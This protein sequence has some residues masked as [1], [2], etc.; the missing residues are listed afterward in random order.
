LLILSNTSAPFSGYS[1]ISRRSVNVDAVSKRKGE[2]IVFKF[3]VKCISIAAIATLSFATPAFADA[4][5]DKAKAFLTGLSPSDHDVV[6]IAALVKAMTVL[7]EKN[8]DA[9]LIA[10]LDD[11]TDF[12]FGRVSGRSPNGLKQAMNS[13]INAYAN[14]DSSI[15][16]NIMI[17]CHSDYIEAR[18]AVS[19]SIS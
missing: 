10:K 14:S 11:A 3:T 7:K 6:C 16:G 19:S 13:G 1:T 12:Y 17:Q 18:K 9:D 5:E 15:L 8:T 4:D 2:V